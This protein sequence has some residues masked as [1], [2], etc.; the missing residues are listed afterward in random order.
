MN[1]L[2]KHFERRS[3]IAMAAMWG[4]VVTAL[5][6]SLDYFVMRFHW[7]WLGERLIENTMEG[8]LFA[9]FMWVFLKSRE[10][11][12]R[13]RF[14]ELGYL[15]HHIRNSL[16]TIQM[17]DGYVAEA[18]QRSQMIADASKR[19]RLCVDKISREQ[20]CKINERSPEQP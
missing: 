16:A 9:L 8:V 13:Q 5:G 11:R 6:M 2:P 20:D 4:L 17:A 3:V 12:F 7:P 19:I 15:N 1:L 14:H 18:A 10:E